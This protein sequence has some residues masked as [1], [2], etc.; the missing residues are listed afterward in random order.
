MKTHSLFYILNN[1]SAILSSEDLSGV[2]PAW[3]I[4]TKGFCEL[5]ETPDDGVIVSCWFDEVKG[6]SFTDKAAYEISLKIRDQFIQ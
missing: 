3:D 5:Q 4:E 2:I 6:Y 1:G